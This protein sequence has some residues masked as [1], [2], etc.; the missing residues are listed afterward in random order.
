MLASKVYSRLSSNHNEFGSLVIQQSAIELQA[1]RV[2]Y[3]QGR[4]FS[5]GR[6]VDEHREWT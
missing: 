1:A 2:W 4:Q 6:E 5:V 3:N